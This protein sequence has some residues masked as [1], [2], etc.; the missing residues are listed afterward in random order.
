MKKIY[1]FI[2]LFLTVI[3][4]YTS[5]R[6]K[7]TGIIQNNDY[8]T[9]ES[10]SNTAAS[11]T[12]LEE[13]KTTRET[14]EIY[15]YLAPEV[16][17]IIEN[18]GL[19]PDLNEN[20]RIGRFEFQIEGNFT[21]SGNR[22]IVAFYGSGASISGAYCFVLDTS[23]EKIEKIYNVNWW[24]TID[25]KYQIEAGPGLTEDLGRYIVWKGDRKIGC[26]GDFNGNGK[27]ELY[28]YSLSGMN[29]QP[30]FF[31]FAETEFVQLLDIGIT[32]AFIDSVNKEKKL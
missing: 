25:Y 1:V 20:T 32:N 19:A 9:T 11:A 15:R 8:T 31:E 10:I 23:E 12:V 13:K 26:V 16:R 7:N 29:R 4:L 14:I 28:L 24:G 2:P 30:Y 18:Y 22:E 17:E 21:D 3:A 5:C 27:D 6:E